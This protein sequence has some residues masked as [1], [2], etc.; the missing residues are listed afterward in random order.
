MN[1]SK[2][3]FLQA[4]AQRLLRAWADASWL[5]ISAGL[6]LLL[7]ISALVLMPF[8]SQERALLADW[9]EVITARAGGLNAKLSQVAYQVR[10][11]REAAEALLDSQHALPSSPLF[12]YIRDST[13]GKSFSLEDV[14]PDVQGN[15]IGNVFGVGHIAELDASARRELNMA[16]WLFPLHRAALKTSPELTWLYYGSARKMFI[17]S[18]WASQRTMLDQTGAPDMASL[19]N[20]AEQMEFMQLGT[21]ALNP[22]R[23]DYWTPPYDD[24]AGKGMMI[25]HGA[26]VYEGKNFRGVMAADLSLDFLKRYV[27]TDRLPGGRIYIVRNPLT[28]SG[29]IL[30]GT[31]YTLTRGGKPET[32]ANHLHLPAQEIET[33]IAN[34]GEFH[35]LGTRYILALPVREADWTLVYTLPRQV[36]LLG[37]LEQMRPAAGVVIVLSLLL[38]FTFYKL[39]RSTLALREMALRDGLTG[40]LN[41][42]A[43][44]D[45]INRE[46]AR[47][48]RTGHAYALILGDIDFF[49]QVNDLHG[50]GTGDQVLCGV[51]Q[52]LQS[53][54]RG[55]DLLARVGGEEFV[56]LLPDTAPEVA[57]QTAERLRHQVE[58]MCVPAGEKNVCV[59]ISLGITTPR[60]ADEPVDAVYQ[61]AD[62]ALYAAKYSGR[63]ACHSF[64]PHHE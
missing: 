63:N 62:I 8:S 46:R 15:L 12:A 28:S 20:K 24:P 60:D 59:T 22:G 42:R 16:L 48:R 52:A 64:F 3:T 32:L 31:Y 29:N 43:I 27:Q 53:G 61:R 36:A 26:P 10:S 5:A 34:P 51:T 57:V 14:P 47:Y 37:V 1:S 33:A 56:I 58:A 11:Q 44:F 38:G 4:S 54:L 30:A 35:K 21:P 9:R 7:I 25:T 23:H 50:H 6:V 17:V 2:L 39:R 13:D 49:K 40:T 18:P 19:V 41:R 55:S 45:A